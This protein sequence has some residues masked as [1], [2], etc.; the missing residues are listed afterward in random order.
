LYI[1]F[2]QNCVIDFDKNVTNKSYFTEQKL[3]ED[4][5]LKVLNIIRKCPAALQHKLP[6]VQDNEDDKKLSTIATEIKDKNKKRQNEEKKQNQTKKKKK[7]SKRRNSECDEIK[8]KNPLEEWQ[9]QKNLN[10]IYFQ[11]PNIAPKPV[12]SGKSNTSKDKISNKKITKKPTSNPVID[13]TEFDDTLESV[14][15]PIITK[16]FSLADANKTNPQNVISPILL[17]EKNTFN[18]D[19]ATLTRVQTD[20]GSPNLQQVNKMSVSLAGKQIVVQKSAGKVI[21]RSVLLDA[22]LLYRVAHK[23]F[24]MKKIY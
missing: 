11:L 14:N 22:Y 6:T 18:S 15:T 20:V 5:N 1:F 12:E 3:H 7:K 23:S 21:Q 2:R 13:L 8:S 16:V 4:L 17:S 19:L 10:K 24:D 9:R